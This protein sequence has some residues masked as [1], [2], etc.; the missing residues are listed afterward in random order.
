[1]QGT[2][3]SILV[4]VSVFIIGISLTACKSEQQKKE[5]NGE[6]VPVAV[7]RVQ[8]VQERE[9]VSVSG[10][11]AT[12]NSPANV[13]F[14]VSGKVVFVGPREGAYVRK[15]QVLARIDPTDFNLSVKGAAAQAA[16]AQ[17]SLEKAMNSARPELLEQARIVYERAE[18]EH[19]R[20]KM[21]YDSKSLAPNDYLK[22]KA[23]YDRAKQDYEQAKIG[24]QKEDKALAKAS[25]NQ[26]A[27]HLDIARKA[28][29]DATLCAP[30][31]GYIAKRSIEPGDTAAAGRT[32]FEI[33]QMDPVEIN[34]GVPETDVHLVRI[35]QKADISVPALPG[36]TFQGTVRVINVSAD[37]STRTYM[38]RISVANSERELRVGMIAEA[39]IR[40]DRTVAMVTLP[41]DVVVRDPQG[42]TQVYVYY[43][44]QKRVYAKRVEVGAVV[45]KNV[46]VKSGLSG[47]ELIVLAGQ[48]KLK[49][50]QAVAATEQPVRK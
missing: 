42:A 2:F 45:G 19:R 18:D 1:M 44:D 5:S 13:S 31:D 3:K 20:M 32:V 39:S 7:G 26:A 30:M 27:A 12:P 23:A 11:V 9:T 50:G 4:T 41:G 49:N 29:S 15:G 10:T 6:A 37:P 34:V 38:T 40:G 8:H 25:F 35:G 24:G 17:A 48:T 28:L 21:L 16:T 22:Y 36:K 43:P 14:L 47:D 46:A 33:V